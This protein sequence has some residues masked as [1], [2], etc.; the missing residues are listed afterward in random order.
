MITVKEVSNNQPIVSA[1]DEI[2]K[3]IDILVEDGGYHVYCDPKC[4]D[5]WEETYVVDED[6]T[7]RWNRAQVLQ[8]NEAAHEA[9]NQYRQ[10]LY[11]AVHRFRNDC[12]QYTIKEFGIPDIA[13]EVIFDMAYDAEH[14]DGFHKT[15]DKC[16]EWSKVVEVVVNTMKAAE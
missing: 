16:R 9:M 13:A 8:H 1:Y 15:L 12:I 7:V 6:Q 11:D 4:Y 10:D 5:I 2:V 3:K 14:D